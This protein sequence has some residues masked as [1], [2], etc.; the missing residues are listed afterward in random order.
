MNHKS[1]KKMKGILNNYIRVFKILS[2]IDIKMLV[3]IIL[4]SIINGII[5]IIS[6]RF[7]Q[8]IINMIQ[9]LNFPIKIL[10]KTLLLY[11]IFNLVAALITLINQ[12]LTTLFQY[13]ID[14]YMETLI[15]TKAGNLT[16]SDFEYTE[17]YN[18]IQRAQDSNRL[19]TYFSYIITVLNSFVTLIFSIYI[20]LTWR[21]WSIII[22]C[23]VYLLS[24]MLINKL[25]KL[26]YEMIRKRTSIEREKWYYKFLLTNDMAFKEIKLYKLARYFIKKFNSIYKIIL[27]QDINFLKKAT[28][29]QFLISFLEEIVVAGLF[30]LIIFDAYLGRILIGDTIAYIKTINNIKSAIKNISQQFSSI[31]KDNLYINQVFEF[32]DM[33]N[34]DDTCKHDNERNINIGNIKQIRIENLSFRYKNSD[35][36][37][38]KKL[39]LILTPG[40]TTAIV[41]RNG[42]GKSTLVKILTGLYDDYEG[43]I[44]IN[45]IDL[46]KINKDF[47]KKQ[48]AILF[49]DFAKFE[50]SLRENIAVSNI[51]NAEDDI[52]IKQSLRKSNFLKFINDIDIRL[53]FWFDNGTQLSGG[54]WMKIGIARVFFKNSSL[55][56]F[57]E[58]NSALDS[59]S[60]KKIFEKIAE[61]SKNKISLIITH[62]ISTISLY[63]QKVLLLKDGK[64]IAY[65]THENLIRHCPEYLE[66][67]EASLKL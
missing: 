28:L 10:I 40:E 38:I 6:V 33:P 4:L 30:I 56:I 3:F 7:T 46:K 62:R 22:L 37:A 11:I 24:T 64:Q 23:A 9:T 54:E 16:L 35:K 50:L 18:K 45:N 17:S 12:Y 53:G 49:Q 48:I 61:V 60:E 67:Y 21:W 14:Q 57:D 31:Y 27:S 34:E 47:Y 8:S 41:G 36:Y 32:I 51:T 5:P 43:K 1:E 44:Y 19:Y 13:K 63:A 59:I 65:D 66:L 2:H 29:I 25:S 39:N 58:P 42:S 55:L 20:L 26:Q 52:A 15:L